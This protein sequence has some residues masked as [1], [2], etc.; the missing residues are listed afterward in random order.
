MEVRFTSKDVRGS[1]T[2]GGR[3]WKEYKTWQRTMAKCYNPNHHRYSNY[4]AKGL[5][6]D[7]LFRYS[8]LNFLN[9]IGECPE[10][11]AEYSIER[12][13]NA[14]GYLSGNIAW[15]KIPLQALNKTNNK[16]VKYNGKELPLSVLCKDLNVN[17]ETV[18]TRLGRGHSLEES[19]TQGRLK[20]KAR[21]VV[22]NAKKMRL[23]GLVTLL[24]LN[25]DKAMRLFNQGYTGDE[26]AE[27]PIAYIIAN[28]I[29]HSYKDKSMTITDWAKHLGISR[30]TLETKLKKGLSI[31]F[32][33]DMYLNRPLDE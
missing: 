33:C 26:I 23:R 20:S 27:N 13:D 17:Y 15:L 7:D 19:L 5:T 25:Y 8:F 18:S 32:I 9:E 14:L 29:L 21:Y 22:Y 16:L 24:K 6:V 11:K 12:I 1:S 31:G 4:G 28:P 10:P 3:F 2:K 30:T